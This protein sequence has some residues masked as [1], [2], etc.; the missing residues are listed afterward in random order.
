MKPIRKLE[1]SVVGVDAM[2]V[3]GD[4]GETGTSVDALSVSWV[5]RRVARSR[6]WTRSGR[7]LEDYGF[8]ITKSACRYI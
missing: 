6:T 1:V 8:I 3:L 4:M 2:K 5:R 7:S